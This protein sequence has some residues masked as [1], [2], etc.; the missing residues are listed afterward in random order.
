[1]IE[2]T[3]ENVQE[4][5]SPQTEEEVVSV[6]PQAAPVDTEQD[7]IERL[8]EERR[9]RPR[10]HS[11]ARPSEPIQQQQQKQPEEEL[12]LGDD[13]LAEGKHIKRYAEKIKV[14]EKKLEA[15]EQ[16][17]QA[18]TAEVRL[19]NSFPDFD[20]VVNT[21]NIE[22]LRDLEP[23]LAASI[24]SNPDLYTKASSAYKLIKKLGIYRED[25]FKQDKELAYANV[26]KPRPLASVSPQQ[27]ESPLQRAN[28]FAHGLTSELK[29]Q[30]LKEMH[31]AR[32]KN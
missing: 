10:E 4:V 12:H 25:N 6:E 2:E 11:H 31:D 14:L 24:N 21:E 20:R 7:R 17:S 26:T 5:V 29:E 28:A 30:L 27:G 22:L 13:D 9:K 18:T 32:R 15:Y 8:R 19:R 1:M 16:T 23:D 3:I